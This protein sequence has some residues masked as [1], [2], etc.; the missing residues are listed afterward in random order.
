MNL[1]IKDYELITAAGAKHFATAAAVTCQLSTAQPSDRVITDTN[2]KKGEYAVVAPIPEVVGSGLK[3]RLEDLLFK[4]LQT[5]VEDYTDAMMVIA[6]VPSV[7]RLEEGS[8]DIETDIADTLEY[9]GLQFEIVHSNEECQA[10]LAEYAK[11]INAGEFE[12]LVWFAA[13]TLAVS[14][15]AG[16]PWMSLARTDSNSD[17]FVLG[18]AVGFAICST[19]ADNAKAQLTLLEAKAEA[20][21]DSIAQSEIT[22][23]A[24]L[25]EQLTARSTDSVMLLHNFA[26]LPSPSIELHKVLASFAESDKPITVAQHYNLQESMGYTGNANLLSSILAGIAIS[27][28]PHHGGVPILNLDWQFNGERA[29]LLVEVL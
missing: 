14:D 11:R 3:I 23:F 10:K 19:K 21:Q 12:G 18:E 22:G 27:E 28:M 4:S 6:Q 5:L 9:F 13:D 17:G 2:P 7:D 29:A 20:N 8:V 1:F 25:A 26:H 16:Q 15:H 24:A